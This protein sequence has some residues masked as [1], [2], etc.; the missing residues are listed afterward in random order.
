M[1]AVQMGERRGEKPASCSCAW[2][3]PI[4]REFLIPLSLLCKNV[5]LPSVTA[6]E[7]HRRLG[8]TADR[9]LVKVR[10]IHIYLLEQDPRISKPVGGGGGGG[11]GAESVPKRVQTFPYSRGFLPPCFLFMDFCSLLW[12]GGL[13]FSLLTPADWFHVP[14]RFQIRPGK[15]QPKFV[16]VS[17]IENTKWVL[18]LNT[19]CE[20]LKFQTW[21]FHQDNYALQVIYFGN[22][23]F[24]P[25][26]VDLG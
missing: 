1:L 19:E 4:P 17:K 7:S 16:S 10:C 12:T 24:C 5:L 9:F 13:L 26:S 14:G 15:L 3:I 20:Y 2:L 8:A 21:I 23:C 18:C 11:R 22:I 6:F 25:G